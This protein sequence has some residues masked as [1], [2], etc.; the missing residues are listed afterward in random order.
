MALNFQPDSFIFTGSHC[1]CGPP[2][3][4]AGG[5]CYVAFCG[6]GFVWLFLARPTPTYNLVAA[7]ESDTCKWLSDGECSLIGWIGSQRYKVTAK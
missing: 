6:A 2:G 4:C 3:G 7:R 5:A 1:S